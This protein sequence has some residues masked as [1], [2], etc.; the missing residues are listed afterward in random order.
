M[1]V[2]RPCGRSDPLR[3][4]HARDVDVRGLERLCR[5]L[6]VAHRRA[7]LMVRPRQSS[8][9]AS[10]GAISMIRTRGTLSSMRA[11]KE[12][13]PD[14]VMAI[15]VAKPRHRQE[16]DQNPGRGLNSGAVRFEHRAIMANLAMNPERGGRPARSRAQAMKLP[17][18]MAIVAGMAMPISLAPS[19]LRRLRHTPPS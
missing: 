8:R 2:P 11:Q 16:A 12:L 7:A 13:M 14:R 10:T 9:R 1:G 17:P 5:R 18:R 6:H 19:P 3:R 4:Q 15:S